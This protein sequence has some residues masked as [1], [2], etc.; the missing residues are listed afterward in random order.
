MNIR[1]HSLF[2]W[3]LCCSILNSCLCPGLYIIVYLFWTLHCMSLLD[4]TLFVSFGHYIVCLF[5]T[6]HCLS[7]LNITLYVSFEHYI[8]CLFW[9]LHCMSLL[10]ITLFVSFCP[11][12]KNNVMS[13]RD[14][15]C[16][17]Q[18]RYTM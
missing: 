7:L 11:K 12:E 13:K 2:Y 16:N 3:G 8:V 14:I 17:V 10:D 9:T 4:I 15:Q 1:V 18:K 5:W 6:L